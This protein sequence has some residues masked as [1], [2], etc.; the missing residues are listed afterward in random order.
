[1]TVQAPHLRG[2]NSNVFSVAVR[3]AV[4]APFIKRLAVGKRC[5]GW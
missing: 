1:M 3:L 2:C 5:K 4:K